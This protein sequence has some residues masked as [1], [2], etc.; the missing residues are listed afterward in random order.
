[1][2]KDTI[3]RVLYRVI[4]MPYFYMKAKKMNI[5]ETVEFMF[6]HNIIQQDVEEWVPFLNYVNDKEPKIII[7]IGSGWG[8]TMACFAKLPSKPKVIAIDLP[9]KSKL[10]NW[11]HKKLCERYG[12]VHIIRENSMD[13]SASLRLNKTLGCETNADILFIDGCHSTEAVTSDYKMYKNYVRKGGLIV[14]HD[15]K[16]PSGVPAFWK[17]IK[18]KNKWYLE[19][20]G[21]N[22]KRGIGVIRK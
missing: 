5:N 21:K 2:D 17:E 9:S 22:S 10:Y 8:G 3:K 7:E 12:N 4:R 16:L 11:M 6:K 20:V 14:F 15:I 1:M 13:F 19:Y 18:K